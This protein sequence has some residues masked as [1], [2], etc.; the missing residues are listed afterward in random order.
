MKEK[1]L[2]SRPNTAGML[3][4]SVR[5]VDYLIASQALNAVKIGRRTG[6]TWYTDQATDPTEQRC[7]VS[8]AGHSSWLAV[9]PAK[10]E[11]EQTYYVSA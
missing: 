10:S 11:E 5:K 1:L 8:I 7:D 9:L 6:R 4:V 2:Y 3:G